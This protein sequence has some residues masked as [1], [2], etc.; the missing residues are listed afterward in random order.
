[1]RQ[2]TAERILNQVLQD[3]KPKEK[4]ASIY[5]DYVAEIIKKQ[6]K[7]SRGIS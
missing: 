7:L 4:E 2:T 3:I 6:I 5:G 1:M